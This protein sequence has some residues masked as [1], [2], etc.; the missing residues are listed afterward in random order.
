MTLHLSEMYPKR[1][2]GEYI[3]S[4]RFVGVSIHML[5]II[6]RPF[7]LKPES[8]TET[9]TLNWAACNLLL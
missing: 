5:R 7:Y 2:F 1:S 4:I 9:S 6:E 3:Y 8:Q